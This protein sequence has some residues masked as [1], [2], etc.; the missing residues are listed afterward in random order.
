M[1]SDR[2]YVSI[3]GDVVTINDNEVDTETVSVEVREWVSMLGELEMVSGCVKVWELVGVDVQRE[4]SPNGTSM[5]SAS[6]T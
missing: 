5:D 4:N 2:E 1:L 3:E 6:Y